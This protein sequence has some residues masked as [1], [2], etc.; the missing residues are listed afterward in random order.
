MKLTVVTPPEPG[1][2]QVFILTP[3]DLA[4]KL[5]DIFYKNKDRYCFCTTE[6]SENST[7]YTA[8]MR[9][10]KIMLETAGIGP[11]KE[12]STSEFEKEIMQAL[13]T[14]IARDDRFFFGLYLLGGTEIGISYR[15]E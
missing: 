4:N 14:L 3:A 10:L 8:S 12:Y 15:I 9:F 2:K 5:P 1:N 11:E 6:H 7:I 13:R